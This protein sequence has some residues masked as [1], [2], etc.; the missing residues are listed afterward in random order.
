MP[1]EPP[2]RSTENISSRLFLGRGSG[3]SA[4]Y[5]HGIKAT[6]SCALVSP[7]SLRTFLSLNQPIQQVPSPRACA[8][9]TRCSPAIPASSQRF[10]CPNTWATLWVSFRRTVKTNT[11]GA[12]DIQEI[13]KREPTGAALESAEIT[14]LSLTTT[15]CQ[16]AA[17]SRMRAQA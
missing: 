3:S 12:P 6:T 9:S 4:G 13:T 15:T 16:R 2:N 10:E 8:A 14:S 17:S 7:T 1:P 5:P 11:N